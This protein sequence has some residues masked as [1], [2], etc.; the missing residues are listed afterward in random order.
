MW[1]AKQETRE[2]GRPAGGTTCGEARTLPCAGIIQIRF[3]GYFSPAMRRIPNGATQDPALARAN[4]T[5]GR[6]RFQ[7][8][9]WPA[10]R[11][12]RRA[13]PAG[14]PRGVLPG[15]LETRWWLSF[16]GRFASGR[17][18]GEPRLSRRNVS[19]E[20]F[21]IDPD[22]RS[23]LSCIMLSKAPSVAARPF[24]WVS[25]TSP[26][27]FSTT[28]RPARFSPPHRLRAGRPRT[29]AFPATMV[30]PRCPPPG[31]WLPLP[32]RARDPSRPPDPPTSRAEP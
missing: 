4:D 19:V 15:W 29:S 27:P 25:S 11:R 10:R 20:L 5:P 2:G 32:C 17:D 22:S 8:L 1:G 26:V 7:P 31:R 16:R 9:A 21:L 23:W 28:C 24:F 18:K 6:P 12:I 3:K 14:L 13:G 30:S